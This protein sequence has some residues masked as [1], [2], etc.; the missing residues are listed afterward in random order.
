MIIYIDKDYR[1]Y[2]EHSEDL[3]SYNVP[4]FDG[5]CLDFI[6]G[7]RYIPEGETWIREDGTKFT[8][9]MISPFVNSSEL[10]KAQLI[11]EKEQA[12][13]IAKILLG[14]E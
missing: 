1:C 10:E 7:Y 6:E 12:E 2:A 9:E 3:S 14:V 11:Y 4:F 5:K 8:G 13:E